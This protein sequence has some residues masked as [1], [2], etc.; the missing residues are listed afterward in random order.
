MNKQIAI[1][2]AHG[3]TGQILT[4]EALA[5]GYYVTAAT[6]RPEQ[7]EEQVRE[8][9][10]PY[11][12]EEAEEAGDRARLRVVRADVYDLASVAAAVAGQDVVVCLV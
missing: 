4:Q 7:L 10:G 3:A 11:L 8:E 5:Q 6:R 9:L 1:F 12:A 2:G